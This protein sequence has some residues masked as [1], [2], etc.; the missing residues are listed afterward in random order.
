MKVNR[1]IRKWLTSRTT[2]HL[3]A[4]WVLPVFFTMTCAVSNSQAAPDIIDLGLGSGFQDTWGG[5]HK[6]GR[7]L[8]AADFD[9]DGR[10]DFYVGNPS[11]E[12]F[13]LRNVTQPGGA[14]RFMF[15]QLLLNDELAWGGAAADY[16]NDGDYDLFISNGG[17][18]GVG[19]DFL[20]RN[21]W[22]ENGETTLSFVDVSEEAGIRGPVPPGSSQPLAVASANAVWGD[23]NADGYVDIF[24]NVT[25]EAETPEPLK[26]RNILWMNNGDG[27]FSDV[28]TQAGLGTTRRVTR[29]S[30]FVDVDNDGDIDLYE[31]NYQDYNVLWRNQLKE[32]GRAT[33]EDVTAEFSNLPTENISLP[34]ESFVSC[35]ADFNNDGWQDIIVGRRGGSPEP[36]INNP[37]PDGHALF[38]NQ[39][40]TGFV[41]AGFSSEL[42]TGYIGERGVMGFQVGD[43]NGDGV[44]DVYI[45]NGAPTDRNLDVTKGGQFSQLYVTDSEVGDDPHFVDI[46]Y[47]IDFPA[48]ELPSWPAGS[49]PTYPYRTHGTSFVDVD[50]DGTIEVAVV[51]GGPANLEDEVREPN[52]LFKILFDG[53]KPSFMKVRPVGDGIKVSK[54][55]IGTRFALTVSKDGG[56]PWTIY[57]TLTGGSCF[58]AQNGF[59]VYFGLK[60]ADKVHS[61]IVR[62]P[63][64][65]TE[66]IVDG[67][68][69]NET[70]IVTFE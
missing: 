50:N 60:N 36:V 10:V 53:G 33:F 30:T 65:T 62:W 6:R 4:H 40:G 66:T 26:G 48:A 8:V 38:L 43:V 16:D 70:N 34:R 61:L 24:V 46:S 14:P 49:Y 19:Y 42:N 58:S 35:S 23:V 5:H 15:S 25:I 37:Y 18:E 55:A 32:T 44:A 13:I 2:P 21:M 29:N 47:L 11:D 7:A 3:V 31:L 56:V 57:N 63:D 67:L 68:Q 1:S 45:G 51:N 52:R 9:L 28:T 12:S 27:T 22:I 54:D 17:N 64:G 59:E 39:G 41:N 69:I 20:F